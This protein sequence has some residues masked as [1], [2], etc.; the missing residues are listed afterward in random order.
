[1]MSAH[2]REPNKSEEPTGGSRFVFVRQRRLAPVA[3]A[4]RS[5][6]MKTENWR[7]PTL[8]MRLSLR[9]PAAYPQS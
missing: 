9:C 8:R 6:V 2:L 3:D 7:R 4:A 1:M 5:P